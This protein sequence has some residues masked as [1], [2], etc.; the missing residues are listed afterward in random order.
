MTREQ[1][2]A[3]LQGIREGRLKPSDLLPPVNYVVRQKDDGYK[4]NDETL[5][6]D[7]YQEL[8]ANYKAETTRREMAGL[9]V[10]FFINVTYGN[11]KKETK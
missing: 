11:R 5:T 4:Y 10:G 2:A 7:Q 1:K 6:P 9:P 3:A 8:R